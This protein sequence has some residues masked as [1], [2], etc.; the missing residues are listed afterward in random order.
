M[1]TTI[2]VFRI[3]GYSLEL[4]QVNGHFE[5][6]NRDNVNN[7][8]V[9]ALYPTLDSAIKEFEEIVSYMRGA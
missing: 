2:K 3:D 9:K 1:S 6:V 4:K 5:I 7:K 8:K